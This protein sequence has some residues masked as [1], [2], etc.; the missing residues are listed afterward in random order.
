MNHFEYDYKQIFDA[1]KAEIYVHGNLNDE[2]LKHA[3]V[4]RNLNSLLS[5]NTGAVG[6]LSR[7]TALWAIK[8]W[9][10]KTGGLG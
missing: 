4:T 9:S 3:H 1:V 2:F 10:L 8:M 5:S 7:K 6:H